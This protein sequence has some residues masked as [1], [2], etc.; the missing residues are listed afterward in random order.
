[1]SPFSCAREKETAELLERGQWPHACPEEL[2]G[3]VEGCR[4]CGELVLVKSAFG[5][6]RV[7]AMTLPVLP[8]ASA[9]WWRAQLRR[10]NEALEKIGR[11]LLGAEIFALAMLVLVAVC[12]LGWALR[13]GSSPSAWF[14]AVRLE[15]L[16]P[17]SL[18]SFAGSLWYVVPLLAALAVVSGLVVYF[19]S[20]KQ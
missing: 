2:R 6:A 3:H 16:W 1:M 8:S 12:G 10:R 7:H 13:H 5:R 18:T 19:A 17:G 20:E 14:E 11:P 9:L 15:T 4:V